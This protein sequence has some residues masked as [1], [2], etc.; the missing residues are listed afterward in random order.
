MTKFAFIDAHRAEFSVVVLCRV[1]GVSTSG[2]YD[3]QGREAAGP[4]DGGAGR[5]RAG[6]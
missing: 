3:W 5:G 4:S 6:R 2:F 1:V